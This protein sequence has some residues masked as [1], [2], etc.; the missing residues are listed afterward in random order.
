MNYYTAHAVGDLRVYQ[1]LF[2]VVSWMCSESSD[3]YHS[4]LHNATWWYL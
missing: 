4:R 2:L 1:Q 3:S